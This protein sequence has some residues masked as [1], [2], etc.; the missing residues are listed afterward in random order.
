[1]GKYHQRME[2]HFTGD[3]AI[4]AAAFKTKPRPSGRGFVRC[5]EI[6]PPGYAVLSFFRNEPGEKL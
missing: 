2:D 6:K 5:R 3:Q 1:M 4:A